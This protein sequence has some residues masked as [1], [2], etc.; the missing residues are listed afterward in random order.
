MYISVDVGGTKTRVMGSKDFENFLDPIIYNTPIDP[1]E[2]LEVLVSQIKEVS[3]GEKILGIAV[4]IPGSISRDGGMIYKT[5]HL[6]G[7]NNYNLRDDLAQMLGA[8]VFI[9]ND[10][11]FVGLGEATRGAGK[12]HDLV[13]YITVST[14]IGGV[15]IIDRK[16]APHNNGFEPGHH[17]IDWES[18]DGVI[19]AEDYL[20]GSGLLKKYNVQPQDIDD[21]HVWD[22]WEKKMAI[23]LNNIAVTMD[24]DTI[25]LGGGLIVKNTNTSVERISKMF[26]SYLRIYDRPPLLKKAELGDIGGAYGGFEYLRQRLGNDR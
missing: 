7:W 18:D 19:Y 17:I 25:I 14:G 5:P 8:P 1:Q 26:A 24:P 13:V 11:A 2:R 22:D 16:I 15:R 3:S 6:H 20:S 21:K 4:G 23:F 9:E 12:E 10:T